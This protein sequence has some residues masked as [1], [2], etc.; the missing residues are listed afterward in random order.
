MVKLCLS[1]QT[2]KAYERSIV[3]VPLILYF[4]T[5]WKVRGELQVTIALPAGKKSGAHSKRRLDGPQRQSGHFG[6]QK[7]FR[8]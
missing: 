1:K 7:S 5:G 6:E 4:D 8:L 3:I 2:V